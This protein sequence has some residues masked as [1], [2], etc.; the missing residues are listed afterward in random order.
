MEENEKEGRS[1]PTI[2]RT[3]CGPVL[4]QEED[5]D[6]S[7][8]DLHPEVADGAKGL[9]CEGLGFR[10]NGPE[11]PVHGCWDL[12]LWIELGKQGSQAFPIVADFARSN[13]CL[14]GSL[15][16]TSDFDVGRSFF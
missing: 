2:V 8:G 4:V 14:V 1:Y 3:R 5:G 15:E 10:G 13:N 7:F 16:T 11:D 6:T 12:I 9:A